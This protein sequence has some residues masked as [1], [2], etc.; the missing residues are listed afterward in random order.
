[1]AG[2][3]EDP[4][5]S[6]GSSAILDPI[7]FSTNAAGLPLLS[8]RSNGQGLKV[9]L[10]FDGYNTDTPF[11]TDGNNATF[12][13]SEQAVIYSAWRDI[14]SFFSMVNVN[15]TTIQPPTGG[16]NPAFVWQR[17]IGNMTGGAAYVGAINNNSSQGFNNSGDAVSRHS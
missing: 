16:S 4:G 17:I 5:L 10:D 13:A 12:N 7:S 1:A 3:A 6:A 9:F 14:V 2:A 8:S 15:V 11:D